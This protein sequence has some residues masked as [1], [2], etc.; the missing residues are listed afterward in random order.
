MEGK[1]QKAP[2]TALTHPSYNPSFHE[3]GRG[4]WGDSLPSLVAFQMFCPAQI[5]SPRNDSTCQLSSLGCPGMKFWRSSLCGSSSSKGRAGQRR[6]SLVSQV[7]KGLWQRSATQWQCQEDFPWSS[8]SN[9]DTSKSHC[10][11]WWMWVGSCLESW[12]S[13]WYLTAICYLNMSSLTEGYQNALQTFIMS[14][15]RLRNIIFPFY[16]WLCLAATQW[17]SQWH[18]QVPVTGSDSEHSLTL[19]HL[20]LLKYTFSLC[21][22]KW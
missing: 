5:G 10:W 12:T 22:K 6:P 15:N 2:S 8:Q 4:N 21:W 1:T 13:Q 7:R 3:T 19:I 16:R 18:T 17:Q 11:I 9:S 14:Q 20:W